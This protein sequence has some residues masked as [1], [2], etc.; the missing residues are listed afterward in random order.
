L[1]S[2]NAA[3]KEEIIHLNIKKLNDYTLLWWLV[4]GPLIDSK[5]RQTKWNSLSFFNIIPI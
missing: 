2:E 1:K 4:L 3:K 5:W